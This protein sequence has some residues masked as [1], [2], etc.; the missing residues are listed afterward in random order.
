MKVTI[1][2]KNLAYIQALYD[3]SVELGL[4]LTLV[5]GARLRN[6]WPYIEKLVVPQQEVSAARVE[7]VGPPTYLNEIEGLAFVWVHTHPKM[8]RF[9]SGIDDDTKELLAAP[10][11]IELETAFSISIVVG[12]NGMKCHVAVFAPIEYE[13]DDVPLVVVPSPDQVIGQIA[14]VKQDFKGKF[15][16]V[17]WIDRWTGHGFKKEKGGGASWMDRWRD[18]PLD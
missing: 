2:L 11:K 3:Y 10:P 17:R 12:H 14:K 15:E 16:E 18:L 13:Q 5:G 6:G 9:W 4:E 7:I 8:S 1:S